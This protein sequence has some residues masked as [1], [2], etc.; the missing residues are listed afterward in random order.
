[1]TAFL[2]FHITDVNWSL[3]AMDNVCVPSRFICWEFPVPWCSGL[4][5]WHCHCSSSGC[6]C[7]SGSIPGPGT[8]TGCRNSHT[9]TQKKIQLLKS[10]LQLWCYLKVE[11]LGR[12]LA[13]EVRALPHD[14][15]S[16]LIKETPER[17]C[18]FCP[19]KTMGRWLCLW[20]KMQA[21][22]RHRRS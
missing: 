21:L 15:I 7:G 3:I 12:W 20:A 19:V 13:P 14:G 9:H 5:T 16:A 10:N 4:R 11:A 2:S 1:M 18:P 8:S 17:S 22:S 6:C